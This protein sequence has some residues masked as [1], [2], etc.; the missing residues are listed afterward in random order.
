MSKSCL[1]IVGQLRFDSV[2]LSLPLLFLHSEVDWLI[3]FGGVFYPSFDDIAAELG[4]RYRISAGSGKV[5]HNNSI[6]FLRL[7]CVRVG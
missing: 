5:M 4:H 7:L 3:I 6:I 2:S 1:C